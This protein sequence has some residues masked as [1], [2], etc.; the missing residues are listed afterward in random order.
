MLKFG[1]FSIL[2]FFSLA[3]SAGSSVEKEIQV[4]SELLSDQSAVLVKKSVSLK[5]GEEKGFIVATFS[6]EGFRGG[7]NFQQ[8]VAVYKPEFRTAD[9]PPFQKIGEPKY[10]LVGLRQLCPSPIASFRQSSLEIKGGEITGICEAYKS[11]TGGET[12]FSLVVSPYDI[13]PKG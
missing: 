6:L 5:E 2:V 11:Q 4:L 10:R 7:N 1:I 3:A 9:Q 12:K 8:Y 13:V